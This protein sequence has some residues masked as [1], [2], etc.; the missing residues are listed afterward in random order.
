VAPDAGGPREIV[1]D[2][3]GRLYAP[4]DARAAAAALSAVLADPGDPRARA[5]QLPVEA[6]AARFKAALEAIT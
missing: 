1:T 5:E 2:R 3:A 6:S 4:G